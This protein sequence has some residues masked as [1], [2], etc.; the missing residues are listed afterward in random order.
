MLAP[1]VKIIGYHQCGEFCHNRATTD[2]ILY[3]CH[4]PEKKWEHNETVHQLFI[5][6]KKTYDSVKREVLYNILLEYGI[7]KKLVR[8]IKMCLNEIYSKICVGKHLSDTFPI[9]IGLKKDA[10]SPVLLNFALEYATRKSKK[11]KPVWN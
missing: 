11:I 8:L 9:Q 10:L 4:I 5:D 6:F 2:Q 3:I 7:P 1:Y